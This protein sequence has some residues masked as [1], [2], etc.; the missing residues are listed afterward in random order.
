MYFKRILDAI[1]ELIYVTDASGVTVVFYNKTWYEY[2]GLTEDTLATGWMDVVDPQDIGRITK[3]IQ[4]A[5]DKQDS[6]ELEF[7]L[8]NGKTNEFRWFLSKACPVLDE[9]GNLESYIGISIDITETKLSIKD[10]EKVYE[11][12][13]EKR[14]NKIKELEKSLKLN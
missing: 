12:E 5:V 9:E 4:N 3:I 7:R 8:R 14:L 1:P 11:S 6:Y 2:T 10:M 13:M